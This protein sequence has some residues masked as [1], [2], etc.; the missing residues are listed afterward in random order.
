MHIREEFSTYGVL[1]EQML[2]FAGFQTIE[3]NYYS[4]VQAEYRCKK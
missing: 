4:K 3:T 2:R 1:L